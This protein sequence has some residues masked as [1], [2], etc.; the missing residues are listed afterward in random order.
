VAAI[1]ASLSRED[2][3]TAVGTCIVLPAG[4]SLA[5]AARAGQLGAVLVHQLRL[6]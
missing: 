2:A 5:D 4:A 3:A 6:R 1:P